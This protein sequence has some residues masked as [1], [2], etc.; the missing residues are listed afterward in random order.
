MKDYCF[1]I[2][3]TLLFSEIELIHYDKPLLFVCKDVFGS[4]Y[5]ALCCEPDELHYLVVNVST[6]TLIKMINGQST[7]RNV[8]TNAAS[9]WKILAKKNVEEDVVNKIDVFEE[10]DLPVE[11]SFYTIE[12][13]RIQRY[14][15]RIENQSKLGSF[16]R[17]ISKNTETVRND[18][19][20]P[21][22]SLINKKIWNYVKFFDSRSY[23]KPIKFEY[24][25][26]NDF[27]EK[28]ERMRD[29]YDE[30]EYSLKGSLCLKEC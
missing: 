27:I 30:C 28:K 21:A 13:D 6:S 10:D 22:S 8:F 15:R 19:F 23:E 16:A 25:V 18:F 9:K 2:N 1:I 20:I 11:D 29:V 14:V 7:M 26:F 24:R 3:S 4:R 17:A 5:L 12:N